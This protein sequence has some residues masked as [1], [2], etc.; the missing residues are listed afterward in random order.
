QITPRPAAEKDTA[1]H[2]NAIGVS[3]EDEVTH[4][5]TVRADARTGNGLP[6]F[7]S[8]WCAH[9]VIAAGWL[10]QAAYRRLVDHPAHSRVGPPRGPVDV[11]GARATWSLG[12]SARP[13]PVLE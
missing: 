1:R 12:K 11:V 2:P 3:P 13:A 7:S 9:Q 4:S 10:A 8:Q 5:I 6:G